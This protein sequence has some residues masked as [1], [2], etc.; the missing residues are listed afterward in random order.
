MQSAPRRFCPHSSELPV[1]PALLQQ[2]YQNGDTNHLACDR[3]MH[4][5][6]NRAKPWLLLNVRYYMLQKR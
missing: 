1:H 6:S 4:L 2:L 3:A 5:F